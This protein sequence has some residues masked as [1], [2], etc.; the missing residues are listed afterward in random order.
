M[1][2][3]ENEI[4]K[5][6]NFTPSKEALCRLETWQKLFVEYNSHTNLMSKNDTDVLFEKHVLDSLAIT[7]FDGFS[8]SKKILDV[9][10]GGGFPSLILSIFFPDKK[11][12]GVDSK[13]KKIKFLNLVKDELSLKNF[14]AIN[15]RI[16]EIEPLN[17]DIVTNRAVGKM[18]DVWRVSSKHLKK[19]G[20][21]ICYK[22]KTAEEETKELL[23]LFSDVMRPK[24][25][26]YNLP[27]SDNHVRKLVIFEKN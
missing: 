8:S 4:Q 7:L 13:G 16:E 15:S 17:V 27:L 21:F 22:A 1:I 24:I 6:F 26:S 5:M 19:K 10:C 9:G 25:I 12:V 14:N 3:I 18:S 23:G 20:Y 2:Q 11:I